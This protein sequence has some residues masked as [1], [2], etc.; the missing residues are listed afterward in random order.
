MSA[1]KSHRRQLLGYVG[2]DTACRMSPELAC[3]TGEGNLLTFVWLVNPATAR[4][5]RVMSMP[6][7]EAEEFAWIQ[8]K[9]CGVALVWRAG[10]ILSIY[11]S[12]AVI[13]RGIDGFIPDAQLRL[14]F[15]A[16]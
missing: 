5:L 3:S 6:R 7:Y 12:G 9:L 4:V 15:A 14:Q 2:A 16:A 10:K 13:W 11:R 1:R 8:S